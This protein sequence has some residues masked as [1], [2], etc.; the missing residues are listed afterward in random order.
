MHS[1]ANL[2]I[3]IDVFEFFSDQPALFGFAVYYSVV[4]VNSVIQVDTSFSERVHRAIERL[5]DDWGVVRDYLLDF[6]YEANLIVVQIIPY[7]RILPIGTG[8]YAL[9]S[10]GCGQGWYKG[11]EH[12]NSRAPNVSICWGYCFLFKEPF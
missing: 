10:V 6:S 4:S 8:P 7:S 12:E 3:G 5:I 9:K 11:Y 2:L 1:P